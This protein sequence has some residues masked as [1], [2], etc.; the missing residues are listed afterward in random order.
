MLD[1]LSAGVPVITN[2]ATATEFPE[3]TVSHVPT[4]DPTVVAARL[5]DLLAHPEEQR[6]LADGGLRFASDH[7]FRHLADTLVSISDRLTVSDTPSERPG[8]MAT[9]EDGTSDVP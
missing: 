4:T 1:A 3:G 7:Q 8:A 9:N 2:L 5:E 6:A